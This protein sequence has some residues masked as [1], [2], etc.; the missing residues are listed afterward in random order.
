MIILAKELNKISEN[1]FNS[2]SGLSEEI[3]KIPSGL[4]KTL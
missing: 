3:S 2:L 4:I 1:D